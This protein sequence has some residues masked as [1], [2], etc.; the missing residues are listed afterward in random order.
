MARIPAGKRDRKIAFYP[1][2]VTEGGLGTE[3]EADGA[4]VFAWAH[5][6]FGT[7]SERRELAQAGSQQAATFRVLSTAALRAA[8]ER[9]EIE[10]L[11]SRWGISGILPIG[12]AS[13]IEFTAVKKGA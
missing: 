13:E 4:P 11:G 9:W 3:V 5:V 7:G 10:F 12:E 1:R 6:R 2:T 8:T